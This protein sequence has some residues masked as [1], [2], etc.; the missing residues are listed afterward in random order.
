MCNCPLT[1]VTGGS[2]VTIGTQAV[3]I[4]N[5][6]KEVVAG[7]MHFIKV[8]TGDTVYI[9]LKGKKVTST[10]YD[11]ILTDSIPFFDLEDQVVVGDIYAVGST[12]TSRVSSFHPIK[13]C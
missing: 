13:T 11:I 2:E 3:L 7:S 6:P 10:N 1:D 5:I 4:G 9:G 8:S 12:A